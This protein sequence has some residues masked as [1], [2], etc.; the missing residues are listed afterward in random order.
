MKAAAIFALKLFHLVKKVI[1][2]ELRLLVIIKSAISRMSGAMAIKSSS[3][4]I[5]NGSHGVIAHPLEENVKMV[6][7]LKNNCILL[8]VFYP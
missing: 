2:L 8:V 5:I 6:T 4:A 3:A 7:V 1:L